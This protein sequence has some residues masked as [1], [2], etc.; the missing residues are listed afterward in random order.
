MTVE[1]FNPPADDLTDDAPTDEVGVT[2]EEVPADDAP[3]DGAPEGEEAAADG[4]AGD[5]VVVTIG[6]ETPPTEEDERRAP[7]WLRD[8]RQQ[9]RSLVRRTRELEAQLKQTQPAPALVEVG[10]KPSLAACDFDEDR[11]AAE[12]ES[13]HDRKAKAEQQ[14][15]EAQ[16]AQVQAAEAWQKRLGEY[17]KQKAALKVPGLAAAEE[18][19]RDVFSVT[20]QALIIKACKQPALMVA[21]LGLNEKEAR[22]LAGI[23]DPVEFTAELVRTEMQVKTQSRKPPPPEKPVPRSSVSGAAA[24]DST[25][26][27]LQEKAAKTGDRTEVVRYLQGKRQ[28]A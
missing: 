7:A 27:K 22:R 15:R 1:V 23:T 8:L 3:P 11:F 6:D 12:L 2:T 16:R 25:L 19:C 28:A 20:Q 17:E 14:T 10:A 13:W 26:A 18:T 24:V 5:E 4:D 9:N 21:A